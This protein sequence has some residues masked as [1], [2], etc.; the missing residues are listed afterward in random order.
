MPAPLAR[1]RA[2]EGVIPVN[3]GTAM[4]MPRILPVVRSRR[5]RNL[6]GLPHGL[7][8]IGAVVSLQAEIA[9]LT[10]HSSATAEGVRGEGLLFFMPLSVATY[11]RSCEG[12]RLLPL[13]LQ[14]D[15][16]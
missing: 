13:G 1:P 9:L 7:A 14:P 2:T 11:R 15:R 4:L 3:R 8:I 16:R 6:R 5:G 10:R 12:R